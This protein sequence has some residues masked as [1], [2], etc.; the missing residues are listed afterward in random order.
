MRYQI[1]VTERPPE[2]HAHRYLVRIRRGSAVVGISAGHTV[3]EALQIAMAEA[4]LRRSRK[5][6]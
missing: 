3:R 1:V 5:T 6:L 2:S 4:R